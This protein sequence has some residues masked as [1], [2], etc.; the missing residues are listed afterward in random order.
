[1]QTAR[2]KNLQIVPPKQE[3]GAYETHPD[4]PKMHQVCIAVGK[5]ASGKTTAVINLIE[6]LR[7]DYVIVVSPT[8]K[9]NEE[10]MRRLKIRPEHILEDP[11]CPK[12]IDRIKEIV[13]KEARDLDRYRAEMERFE[14]LQKSLK[15]PNA[16][17]PDEL[18]LSFFD[19]RQF[20]KPTHQWGGR[21][22]RIAVLF[23]DCM[24]SQ[25][26]SKP[27]KLNAL[28]TYSRHIGQLKEGGSIGV[29]LFFL[30]QSFKAQA[31]GLSKVIRNQC[32]SMILFRTKDSA[33]L[34][35]V[36]ESVA[37]EVDRDTFLRVYDHAIGDGTGHPFLFIDLHRKPNHAS[38][39][40]RRFDEF[41]IP[42]GKK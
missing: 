40:R 20:L 25:L 15:D 39:F 32:T 41:L 16:P 2:V 33:E 21:K 7:F 5:R 9:S 30:I 23:D 38:M 42:S 34:Q 24:G 36:A 6:R 12:V 4:L 13:E 35:D 18:L 37:G 10:M 29:S 14:R 22:P 31:G 1:M 11:D 3:S 26:Y 8:V 17:L 28:S 27:R 19:D